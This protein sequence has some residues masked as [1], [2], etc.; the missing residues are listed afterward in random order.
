MRKP[1]Y[2]VENGGLFHGR[3]GEMKTSGRI[4]K[5]SVFRKQTLRI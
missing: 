1:M 4:L 2:S 5:N 3:L